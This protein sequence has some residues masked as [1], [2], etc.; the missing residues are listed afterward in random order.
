MINFGLIKN[1]VLTFVILLCAGSTFSFLQWQIN[2]Q[3]KRA[4][5]EE[6]TTKPLD[7]F[8][9][10]IDTNSHLKDLQQKLIKSGV[11]QK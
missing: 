8:E 2:M 11:V 1:T 3:V 10:V 5:R 7:V 6:F 9:V 4:I